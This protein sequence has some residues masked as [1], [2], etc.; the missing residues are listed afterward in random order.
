MQNANRIPLSHGGCA[1]CCLQD[2]LKGKEIHSLHAENIVKLIAAVKG[3]RSGVDHDLSAM[4]IREA[5]R[6]QGNALA[7]E[8]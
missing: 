1:P 6:L 2:F 7:Q 3:K 4:V 8:L 5:P